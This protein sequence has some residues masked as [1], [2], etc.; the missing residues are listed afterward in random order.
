MLGLQTFLTSPCVFYGSCHIVV[1]GLLCV[2]RQFHSVVNCTVL[3]GGGGG[4]GCMFYEMVVMYYWIQL[5]F[6]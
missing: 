3:R 4:G 6:F 1:G 2:V 5:L